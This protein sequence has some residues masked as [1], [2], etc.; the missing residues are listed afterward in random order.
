MPLTF[1]NGGAPNYSGQTFTTANDLINHIETTLVSAGWVSITKVVGTSVLL[2]G[3]SQTNNH[4][5]WVEFIYAD[6]SYLH[7]RGW[8]EQAKTNGSPQSTTLGTGI[9]CRVSIGFENRLWIT[10]NSDAGCICIIPNSAPAQGVHFGFLDRIDTSDQWAWMVGNIG[11]VVTSG[12]IPNAYS[13]KD[14][15][16]LSNNISSNWRSIAIDMP[17][18]RQWG[19]Y[20]ATWA[21]TNTGRR[22]YDG[23]CLIRPYFWLEGRVTSPSEASVSTAPNSPY[24]RGNV[25]YAYTGMASTSAGTFGTDPISG[26]RFMSVGDS[27]WQ[28]MRIA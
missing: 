5:C 8:L 28:G 22:N 20:D 24:F 4:N 7:V 6:T 23:A 25:Q 13:A 12:S 16:S 10:A 17:M 9:F 3:T 26:F 18:T 21:D 15:Y 14:K 2:K 1:L 19:T 11:N 27:S